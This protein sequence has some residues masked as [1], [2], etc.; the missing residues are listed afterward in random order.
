MAVARADIERALGPCEEAERVGSPSGMGEC[1][2]VVQNG[3]VKACKVITRGYDSQRFEREVN[4][5]QRI[6][7]PRVVRV[8]D[9]GMLTTA[10]DG[11]QH[12]YLLSEFL[13][14]GDVREHISAGSWPDDPELRAFALA[15]L[16]GVAELHGASV[17]HRDLK[18]E[19]ILLLNGDWTQPV[20]IDLGLA[21]LIDLATVTVYPWAGGTWPYM[22]PEQLQGE[23][24]FER[25]DIW[26]VAV[27]VAE[28]AARQHPFWRGEQHLPADWDGRLQA[29]MT[30]P[31]SRPAGLRDWL[32]L[33]GAYR[34]Y[35]RPTATAA[36]QQ[37][38]SMWP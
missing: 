29:G 35:R 17:V 12:P 14:G 10:D 15:V 16:E 13:P 18:P 19:N 20:I 28:L 27:T 32:R 31:G 3:A 37:L 34:G 25:T 9:R 11:Q 33:A 30:I 22:A 8:L 1:W 21:R 6:N 24:A 7:S 23:R 26:A 36:K 4:A 38:E 5:M 2:R